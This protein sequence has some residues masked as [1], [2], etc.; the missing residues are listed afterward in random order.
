[1]LEEEL[2]SIYGS[3]DV[4]GQEDAGILDDGSCSEG[5]LECE[6]RDVGLGE[7]PFASPSSSRV[8]AAGQHYMSTTMT[9]SPHLDG[10]NT[11]PKQRCCSDVAS[12]DIKDFSMCLN[13]LN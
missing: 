8:M 3:S 6:S 7:N 13:G 2:G 10:P 11:L 4:D 1:M 12:H 9:P 5:D